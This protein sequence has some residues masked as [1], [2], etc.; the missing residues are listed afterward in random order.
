LLATKSVTA[1]LVVNIWG[2]LD[3]STQAQLEIPEYVK[4]NVEQEVHAAI[5][6]FIE[7]KRNEKI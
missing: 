7:R 4:I 6:D 2:Q 3:A 1:E 5:Q